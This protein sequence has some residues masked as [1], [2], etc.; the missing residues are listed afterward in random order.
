MC[1][2][3][4]IKREN[5]RHV[6]DNRLPDFNC[7]FVPMFCDFVAYLWLLLENSPLK[8]LWR[9]LCLGGIS[10]QCS[11]I[12]FNLTKTMNKLIS[13]KIRV[14]ISLVGP[15]RRESHNFFS[16]WL[17][18]GTSEPKFD[19]IHFFN[20]HSQTL[21]D[22]MQKEIENLEF[23]QGVNFELIDSLKNLGTKNLVII[24]DSC[25]EICNSKAFV[26]IATGAR[27]PGLSIIYIKHNLFHRSKLGRDA[28]LRNTHIVPFKSP[29]DVM[30][31]STPGAQSV[32]ELELIG[33]RRNLYS[34][35][36]FND[37]FV[38]MDRWSITVLYRQWSHSLKVLYP[39]P[40]ET[41]ETFG[42]WTQKISLVSKFYNYFP[43]NANAF[44]FSLVQNFIRF[45]CE[46]TVNLL[47]ENLQRKKRHHVTKF[48]NEIRLLSVKR[49]TWKQRLDVRAYE[50][51]P[52]LVNI[53]NPPVINHSSWHGTVCLCSWFCVQK[54][55]VKY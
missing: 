36:S 53:I 25:E 1:S 26:D 16:D 30:Q 15:P 28:E 14:F 27:H 17:N 45:F 47:K 29:R 9:I 7:V 20:Q 51:G 10:V 46:C 24:G 32:L 5:R 22:V 33:L 31:V 11:M 3:T 48:Q 6:W 55:M 42:R 19:T 21:Y 49:I 34:L 37:W 8:N 39:G 43:T 38:A 4:T 23:G 40:V 13:T 41:I 35:R 44:S 52:K 12:H 2:T 54:Q 50:R 18:N